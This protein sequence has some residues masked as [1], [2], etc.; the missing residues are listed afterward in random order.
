M[1]AELAYPTS[2]GFPLRLSVEGS[3]AVQVKAQGN[4]DLQ[5]LRK[6]DKNVSLKLKLIPSANIE[7]AGRITLDAYVVESGLKVA[8]TVYT[9]TGGD[10]NVELFERGRGN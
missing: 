9:A 10:I 2:L 7:I 3:S 5:A 6:L 8:S 4:I 1:E